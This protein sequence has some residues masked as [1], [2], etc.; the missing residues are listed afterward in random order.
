MSNH[1]AGRNPNRRLPAGHPDKP[2]RAAK[3]SQPQP[4]PR[5]TPKI[6]ADKTARADSGL[7]AQIR[8]S[9]D[10]LFDLSFNRYLIVR[11]LPL[12]YVLL[13][14]AGLIVIG[15]FVWQAYSLSPTRGLLGLALS[16]LAL[17]FWAVLSRCVTEFLLVFFHM[18]ADVRTLSGIKPTVDRIDSL[19]AGGNWI[20]RIVPFIKAVQTTREELKKPAPAP[21]APATAPAPAIVTTASMPA[22]SPSTSPEA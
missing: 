18:A 22:V 20:S 17:L 14:V 19:F 9:F 12:C 4:Q 2:G 11:L 6:T 10:L 16:P 21:V 1:R 5:R 8:D 3:T 7:R 13:V 15:H